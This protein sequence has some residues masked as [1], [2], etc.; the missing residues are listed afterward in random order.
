MPG[1]PFEGGRAVRTPGDDLGQHRVEPTADVAAEADPGVDA[2][3]LAGRP[4]QGLDSTGRGQEAIL[5][6]LGIEAHLDGVARR[7]D[8]GPGGDPGDSGDAGPGPAVPAT[9]KPSPSSSSDAPAAI[10]S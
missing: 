6:V 4:A 1:Q 7:G 10:A 2:D 3:A 9:S 5:G 8:S